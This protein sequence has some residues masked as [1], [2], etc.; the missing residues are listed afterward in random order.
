MGVSIDQWRSAIGCHFFNSIKLATKSFNTSSS[1]ISMAKKKLFGWILILLG[2][3]TIL[4]NFVYSS[5]ILHSTR[6]SP[7]S[8][9]DPQST[10][11]LTWQTFWSPSSPPPWSTA[12]CSSWQ[13]IS[14]VP[15]LP[16][17]PPPWPP[18][19]SPAC[20]PPQCS[21]WQPA[22]PTPWSPPWSPACTPPQCSAWQPA[23]PTPL[24]PP[25][26]PACPPPQCSA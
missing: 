23:S 17:W 18:P 15:W 3:L 14:S 21:A 22:S 11:P 1:T 4:T 6:P 7:A 20:P 26:C 13:P 19:W 24:S 25:W 8:Q 10:H 9:P 5:S 16:P 12:L 2:I